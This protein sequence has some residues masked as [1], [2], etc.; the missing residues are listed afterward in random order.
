[1]TWY[2]VDRQ[3]PRNGGMEITDWMGYHWQM[4]EHYEGRTPSVAERIKVSC[5]EV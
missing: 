2:K 1:M 5:M 4:V 3:I